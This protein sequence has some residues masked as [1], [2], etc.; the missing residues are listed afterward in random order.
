MTM[1]LDYTLYAL[2]AVFFIITAVSFVMLIETER[3]LWVVSTVVLGLL[4]IGLGYSQRPK[5]RGAATSPMPTTETATS[6]TTAIAQAP[7][8]PLVTTVETAKVEAPKEEAVQITMEPTPVM[9]AQPEVKT[10]TVIEIPPMMETPAPAA[11]PTIE[12]TQVKGIG[13]KRAA[14]LKAI[15]I[16]SIDELAQT[17]SEE[18]AKKLQIS[19][20]IVKKW[21][22]GAKELAK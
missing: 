2:A 22:A 18:V 5:I 17:S 15:G 6:G 14:Q 11:A 20:K 13:E 16:N 19:P 21:I 4:S 10:E 3:N 9:E 1:R 7:Q 8:T 12:L